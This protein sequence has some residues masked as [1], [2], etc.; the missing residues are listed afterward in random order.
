MA[1]HLSLAYLRGDIIPKAARTKSP[2]RDK[3]LAL[4]E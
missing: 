4:D 2:K 1:G 3:A